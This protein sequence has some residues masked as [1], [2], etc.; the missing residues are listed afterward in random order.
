M[1]GDQKKYNQELREQILSCLSK[2]QYGLRKRLNQ[3]F[4]KKDNADQLRDIE[5]MRSKITESISKVSNRKSRIPNILFSENL[6]VVERREEIQRLI[7]QHQVVI[8]CGETG[9]GKTT[10]LPKMLLEIGRGVCGQIA[11]TQ[12]RRIAARSV[13][14]RLAKELHSEIG[15][16]VGYQVRF[17]DR[18][19]PNNLIKVMT[20]GVL[21]A[22]TQTDRHLSRYDTIIIDE[23]HERNL[24][25]DF[26]FGYLKGLLKR[27]LDLKLVITSATIDSEKFSTHF[28][29][30]PVIE[31]SG[32]LYP[33]EIR[34]QPPGDDGAQEDADSL[35]DALSRVMGEIDVAQGEGDVL[36]FLPGERE[37]RQSLDW[38]SKNFL[39]KLRRSKWEA[40][41]LYSKLSVQDQN[42]IFT[43]AHCRRVILTTNI[44]E[45]SLTIPKI[46]YVIDSGLAR[47]KRYSYRN[48]VEMLQVEKIS[49]ASANQRAGRSGRV[50]NGVCVRLYSEIDFDQRL[51]HTEPEIL[52]SSLASV[53]LRMAVFGLEEPEKFPFIDSPIPRALSD[54]YQLL[55]EL[56]AIDRARQLT[57]IGKKIARIPVDPRVARM[58]LASSELGCLDEVLKLA[59]GLSVQDPRE[60]EFN[61]SDASTLTVAEEKK[62]DFLSLLEVWNWFQDVFERKPGKKQLK[63]LCQRRHL[64]LVRMFEWRELYQQLKSMSIEMGF[65]IS[66][67]SGERANIHRAL[68]T[69][70]LGNIGFRGDEK[71]LYY[72][73]RSIKFYIHPGSDLRKA[74]PKWIIASELVETSRLYA[75]CV[76]EID[77]DW[78]EPLA[79]HLTQSTYH[80]PR[81]SKSTGNVVATERVTL[82]G[83][84][85]VPKRQINYG[86]INSREAREIFI[87][88]AL[89]QG[90]VKSPPHFL[91]HNLDLIESLESVEARSR[92]YDLLVDDSVV[93]SFFEEKV[94]E[95]IYSWTSFE[96]WRKQVEAKEPRC[97][98]LTKSLL[99]RKD[100]ES[101]TFELYPD[102]VT[103]NGCE[104]QLEYRFEPSHILDGVTVKVP[105]EMLNKIDQVRVEWLVPGLIREKVTEIIKGL[106]KIIRKKIFPV[107][108][109]VDEIVGD[110]NPKPIS[111]YDLIIKVINASYGELV[112][113][114]V[115]NESELPDF[116]RMNFSVVDEEGVDI[117]SG[118]DLVL[119][120][121]K[122]GVKATETFTTETT[123]EFKKTGVTIWNFGDL[124]EIVEMSIQDK[125]IVGFPCLKDEKNSVSIVLA[126]TEMEADSVT[127]IGVRRLFQLAMKDQF[128]FISK[129]W[130]EL[131]KMSLQYSR[132]L[133]EQGEASGGSSIQDRLSDELLAAT[134]ARAIFFDGDMIRTEGVFLE[135]VKKAKPRIVVVA[136][137][138][139]QIVDATFQLYAKVRVSLSSDKL[140]MS[141]HFVRNVKKHLFLLMSPNFISN[142]PYSYLKHFPRY[143][144][145]VFCRIEKLRSDPNRDESWQKQISL[146]EEQISKLIELSVNPQQRQKLIEIRWSLEEL[147]VSLWAQQLKTIY[148]V[149]FKRVER[150]IAESLVET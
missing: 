84:V 140:L 11:H 60:R 14:N 71:G 95:H 1:N 133:S 75:R 45:T 22:E 128:K 42:R 59:A 7:S 101:E 72:G 86:P 138:I 100:I 13:A 114:E 146:Y 3:L 73:A 19:S 18:S 48:K 51:V 121:K 25:V 137:E 132:L 79:K 103:M 30:A 5:L 116:L 144:E 28:D 122:L 57:P 34:Y 69:G 62:S 90:E 94:P 4:S 61:S 35:Y 118:R 92:R 109:F 147:R 127:K 126:D 145:A 9:S 139:N 39:S 64:S 136:N 77:V 113:R 66:D 63:E 37:I 21:L 98:Y 91:K 120:R 15:D 97:L 131:P 40:L 105:I 107:K 108:Q 68:L 141:Q 38:L 29:Q 150:S 27:R 142:T 76:A 26:L 80:E 82:Y 74:K 115:V 88:R 49:Q 31:V 112:T 54:G 36:V 149:S 56:G 20:D 89:V 134:S 93:Y 47:V 110:L 46:Q 135:A 50:M 87:R 53:I 125:T 119:L 143:L 2:D 6:P 148:P 33:V 10:Q 104:F 8:L 52:R 67:K 17:S 129:R 99:V 44:A 12:P 96:K 78:I 23:A 65:K 123:K 124:P 55:E 102:A 41:P 16:L 81:W 24:N 32:R 83:L 85:V 130:T 58:I 111:L 117:D 43:P 106:P 70:L